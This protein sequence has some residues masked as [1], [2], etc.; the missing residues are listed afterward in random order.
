MDPLVA[1]DEHLDVLDND[2]QDHRDFLVAYNE[3]LAALGDHIDSRTFDVDIDD[4]QAEV[5]VHDH[6]GDH[7]RVNVAPV[8]NMLRMQLVD[9]LYKKIVIKF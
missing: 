1:L 4:K 2:R 3:D 9:A 8:V 6:I 7:N 5:D